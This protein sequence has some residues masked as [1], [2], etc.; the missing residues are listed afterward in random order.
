MKIIKIGALWC[1]GCLMINNTINKLKDEYKI[2][3]VEYDF[4]FDE[5]VKKYNIGNILPVLIIEKNN[6]EVSRLIGERTYKEIKEEI[7]K[8]R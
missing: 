6:I 5:D 3:I 4:D 7:E 2:E 8:W 1:P